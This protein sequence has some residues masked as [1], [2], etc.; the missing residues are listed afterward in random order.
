MAVPSLPARGPFSAPALG[1]LGVL[2]LNDHVLKLACP[3]WITGKASDVA[4]LFLFPILVGAFGG[5]RSKAVAT[6]AA[7]AGGVFF[8]LCKLSPDACAF[9]T[10]HLARTTADPSDLVAL[11]MLPAT[12]DE[13]QRGP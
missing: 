11:P 4:G 8:A 6:L 3:S 13:L 9:V 5:A 2:V 1:A 7:L 10:E 12:L